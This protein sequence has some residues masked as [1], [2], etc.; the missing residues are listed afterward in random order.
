MRLPVLMDTGLARRGLRW[1]PRYDAAD[2]LTATV[3]AA[4]ERGIV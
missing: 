2:T 1:R 4:R 3:S